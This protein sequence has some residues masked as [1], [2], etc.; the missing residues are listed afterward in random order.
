MEKIYKNFLTT[1]LTVALLLGSWQTNAQI[2]FTNSNSL[3]TSTDWHSGV[4][5]GVVDMNND[6]LDDIL[7]LSQGEVMTIEYQVPGGMFT[8]F[9]Y[10]SISTQSQWA[11]AAGDINNDGYN[12]VIGGDYNYTKLVV[13]SP[14]G[15]SYTHSNLPGA[16]FFAQG[17]NFADIN[18]DGLIDIFACNDDAESRIWSNN[19][20]GTFSEADSWIDMA[21][22][23]VSDN[24]GNYGSLWTD[25]DN[26]GDIDLY[27]AK[28]RQGVNDPADPRR[29]NALFVNDGN[30]NYT[31]R[32]DEFGLK[33][34]WQSWTSD[35]NDIDND[36]D[37]DVF[38]TNHDFANMLMENDGSGHFRDIST[39]QNIGITTTSFPI[40]GVMRDFDNDGFMDILVS[41][42]QHHLYKNNGDKTFTEITGLFNDNQIESFALGD[43]NN[44]GFVDIYASYANIY[45]NPSNIDDVIWM[46]DAND[47]NWFGVDLVGTVSNK[48]AIG[49]RI[50]IYGPWGVQIRDVR[51]G[52][53][54][55]IMNSL[56]H[57]FGL[58]DA[59]AVDYVIVKWPSGGIDVI[60]NPDINEYLTIEE[61]N[62]DPFT[63]EIAADGNTVLCEGQTVELSAPDGYNYI[64]NNGS[65]TSTID[66]GNSGNYSVVVENLTTGCFGISQN[67]LIEYEP[68][69][70]PVV[71]V[72]GDLD[73]CAGESVILT[74]S[75]ATSYSWSNGETTQSITVT[76]P[77]EYF[78]TTQGVCSE[79]DSESFTV[80][81]LDA[82]NPVADD[83]AVQA[84]PVTLTATGINPQW[85]DAEVGGN[86]LGEGN[87]IE[88]PL[89][90]IPTTFWVEDLV[91]YG[92]APQN[93]G[94]EMYEGS[95]PYN[96]NQTNAGLIFNVM[97]PVTINSVLVYT[98]TEGVRIIE[99]RNSSGDVIQSALVNIPVT[100]E[101]GV[102]IDLN[103]DVPV[104]D[105][106]ILTTN[107]NQN[108]AAFGF[109]SPRLQRASSGVEFPYVIDELINVSGPSV[110]AT[111][112]Y[113]FFDWEVQ[114][115]SLYCTSDR[116]PVDVSI[117]A[118]TYSIEESQEV[119][120]FPNPTD[121]EISLT[122]DFNQNTEVNL[123]ITD[124]AG[125]TV[126]TQNIGTVNG[127][128]TQELNLNHLAKGIYLVQVVT[129]AHS[130]FGKI[131]VQ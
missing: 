57:S 51:A 98:D 91:E 70:T 114:P 106:Y 64:W 15:T 7:R 14:D 43:L 23:P 74:S 30:N 38:L 129:P 94:M 10:G 4:A 62:C 121:G 131:A 61:S 24:S 47:N 103:F 100:D 125:K 130:Y 101:N 69:E 2:S 97:A 90:E 22:S 99:V 31:E 33:I 6:K 52:E 88:I 54:Y 95:N 9:M 29:I 32:A 119:Q 16:S 39:D 109:P 113:Y 48:N 18:N 68:D 93:T 71:T 85:Y 92:S 67:I 28:C 110:G 128:Q 79:N 12:D 56:K 21:T 53:S 111:R 65:T 63:V 5:V 55:G 112:Y 96:S 41:G 50:E 11:M 76:T 75:D 82:D 42:S 80:T 20:D 44:D 60:E 8:P 72:E 45:T 83:V 78:V 40:Q 108:N 126:Y 27:I 73:F 19:G 120:L 66:A 58:G 123:V 36:G 116:I 49:A 77:G 13:A 17:S 124:L 104:G 26:D 117:L 1:V 84:G 81:V 35:F 127:Q 115:S 37:M 59:T 122:L 86:F 102:R 107:S 105:A 3:L 87:M 46:N 89:V 118:S 34:G 25:F